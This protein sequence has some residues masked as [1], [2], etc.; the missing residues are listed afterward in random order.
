[1]PWPLEHFH[2]RKL[3]LGEVSEHASGMRA[4]AI[5][6]V[7]LTP[8]A[9]FPLVDHELGSSALQSDRPHLHAGAAADLEAWEMHEGKWRKVN[10]DGAPDL[11]TSVKEEMANA[12]KEAEISVKDVS[13]SVGDSQFGISAEGVPSPPAPR[14]PSV[15]LCSQSA[16]LKPHLPALPAPLVV[17][18]RGGGYAMPRHTSARAATPPPPPVPCH[19]HSLAARADRARHAIQ[20]EQLRRG[21]LRAK[22]AYLKKATAPGAEHK[23]DRNMLCDV[24]EKLVGGARAAPRRAGDGGGGDHGCGGRG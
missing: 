22:L 4:A 6:L 3:H 15:L 23:V 8:G 1:V 7:L 16:H 2:I 18:G 24:C 20:L 21:M 5:A 11:T 13:S 10:K 9:A 14:A 17:H 19:Q 12:Q